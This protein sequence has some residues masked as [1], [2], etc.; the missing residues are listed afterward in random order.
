MDFGSII[1]F[2]II[3]GISYVFNDN[4]NKSNRKSTSNN[5]TSTVKRSVERKSDEYSSSKRIDTRNTTTTKT[6]GYRNN[7]EDL[8]KELSGEF[9]RNFKETPKKDTPV[10]SQDQMKTEIKSDSNK[11]EKLKSP[12]TDLKPNS[13]IVKNSVY[14]GEIGNNENIVEFNERSIIQGVIMSEILQK[15]KSLRR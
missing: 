15:P 3:A 13:E 6:K 11:K 2:L 8:F 9:N 5:K 10:T 14:D 7:L 1:G 4:K 12:N